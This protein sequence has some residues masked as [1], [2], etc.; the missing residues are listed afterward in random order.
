MSDPA[1]LAD[2]LLEADEI[3]DYASFAAQR[4][5]RLESADD[6]VG[7]IVA[8]DMFTREWDDTID[9]ASQLWLDI[10][11]S[12]EPNAPVDKPLAEFQLHLT[13]AL[14]KTQVP[15]EGPDQAQVDRV[16]RYVG[17]ATVN[18][19][20][21][22]ATEAAGGTQVRWIS[23]HDGDVRNSHVRA[24]GQTRN[25]DEP[26]EVGG[27]KLRYPGDPLGPPD[28]VINCRCIIAPVG[29]LARRTIMAAVASPTDIELEEDLEEV[30]VDGEDLV[31]DQLEVPWHSVLAPEEQPTGD[32]RMFAKDSISWRN[33]PLPLLYQ[34][35]TSTSHTGSVRVGR[36]DEVWKDETTSQIRARGVFN[37]TPDA[38][39]VIE[40]IMDG[41]IRG[42]SVDVDDMELDFDRSIEDASSMNGGTMVFKKARVAGLTIVAIPAYQEAY[43]GLGGAFE[44]ELTDEDY[45][46]LAA[47]G[48]AGE[49]F[50]EVST[51]E[52]ERLA[53]AGEAMPDG[54]FPIANVQDLRNAIQAIGRASDPEAVKAH[55]KKRARELGAENLIPEGWSVTDLA[56]GGI[57]E[58]DGT[59]V[60]VGEEGAESVIPLTAAAGTKDGPGWITNPK[61]TARIRSYWTRGRG[62][63]KIR[64]GEPGD[65]NRC[66]SQLAKYVRNPEW[67]A[68]TC[69]N[70]H[71]EAL[72]LWPGME[73]GGRHSILTAVPAVTFTASASRVLPA[74]AFANPNLS[75]PTAL[76][77]ST[78][79]VY[80]HLAT[81]GVCHIGIQDVCTT[82]PH[83]MANYAYFRTGVVE[84]DSG[85]VAVGQI[86]MKTGHA[87]IGQSARAAAAH[88]D[89]TGSV[90]ADVAAG[91]DAYGIWVAG[92]LRPGVSDADI[93]ELQAAALSGDWRDIGGNLELVA[94]LAVNV[95]GF[96]IPR[97]GLAASAGVTTS[98]VAAG[99]VE[100]AP[101]T[102]SNADEVA[103]VARTAVQEYIAE[104]ARQEQVQ[105]RSA[106]VAP[107]RE[108]V[109]SLRLAAV[110]ERFEVK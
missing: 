86:T 10:F 34:H 73:R 104:M 46:L 71:K 96:P 92:V 24:D 56:N 32:G 109:K 54:S 94:A 26:F 60:L 103:A 51:A 42:V 29:R 88:Y 62:A 69:A 53:K 40:G 52:R 87:Q 98:L 99:V 22:A 107:I 84:T 39:H 43:I 27:V 21:L 70:M 55:I 95:P 67:L 8:E 30:D 59:V 97:I 68:G 18:D 89:N 66:R 75:G 23:M 91:E 48:C 58:G 19:A 13:A 72:G 105:A 33:L 11:S 12:I 81:W 38:Q 65:F 37:N 76:T 57:V 77:V 90:V 17:T 74:D 110:R 9:A 93:D 102:F 80:G 6:E 85:P 45:A 2:V 64:W 49:A 5:A 20:T 15:D 108:Q 101:S 35:A 4:T 47:C 44:D 63:A 82:A 3:L 28:E 79:R 100:S 78:N 61:A 25:I 14:N 36:I 7:S 83:S 106:R 31:D 50:R 1:P 41:S 16:T